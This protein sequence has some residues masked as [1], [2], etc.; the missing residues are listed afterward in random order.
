M[1][2]KYCIFILKTGMARYIISTIIWCLFVVM[3]ESKDEELD[4]PPTVDI[5]KVFYIPHL[6]P[7]SEDEFP[8][9]NSKDYVRALARHV[10][11]R[12]QKFAMVI[13]GPK[14][15][16]K[17]TGIVE[18]TRHWK[19]L[20]HIIIDLNLKGMPTA[21]N[22]NKVMHIISKQ[23]MR[24]IKTFD[25]VTYGRIHECTSTMC[26]DQFSVRIVMWLMQNF[27]SVISF[28]GITFATLFGKSFYRIRRLYINFTYIFWT[29]VISIVLFLIVLL[30]EWFI[31]PHIMYEAFQPIDR[32]LEDGDWTTL[33]CYMNCITGAKP[34]N[35]TILIIREITNLD[36]QTLHEC[37]RSMEQFK[38]KSV[39]FPILM[40]TSDY[41][42]FQTPAVKKSRASFKAYMME[43]MSFKEGQDELVTRHKMFTTEQYQH[44]Y[45][46][47]GGHIGS[48][49]SL[50]Y[51]MRYEEKPLKEALE[52]LKRVTEVHLISCLMQSKNMTESIVAL[53]ELKRN[54]Y[55]HDFGCSPNHNSTKLP[56]MISSFIKCNM[57]FFNGKVVFPQKR[58]MANAIEDILK[59]FE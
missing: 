56:A 6:D 33:I 5:S 9:T 32:D 40:E 11:N 49:E 3:V 38:E 28:L 20:G 13:V 15:I 22:G 43:E 23:L 19:S 31:F 36:N 48:Y 18:M 39:T 47:I 44:I 27:N 42:W 2:I 10:A 52:N 57:L 37:L 53:Q 7:W 30:F 16:G 17:S 26:T 24:E 29:L 34:Q 55:R 21:I 51:T 45:D 58:L 54:G 35:R 4:Y 1:Y 12:K 59:N 14:D 25:L 50:W 41:L 46:V 8:F